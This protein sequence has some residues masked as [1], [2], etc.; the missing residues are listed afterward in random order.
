MNAHGA[1]RLSGTLFIKRRALLFIGSLSRFGAL[2]IHEN[3]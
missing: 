1:L 2:L 3:D